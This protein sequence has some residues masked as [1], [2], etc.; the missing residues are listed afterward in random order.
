VAIVSNSGANRQQQRRDVDAR[1]QLG[2]GLGRRGGELAAQV[3]DEQR[4]ADG[5]LV[6]ARALAPQA[7]RAT[8]LAVVGGEQDHRVRGDLGVAVEGAQHVADVL[9]DLALELRVEVE[10]FDPFR[11]RFRTLERDLSERGGG[12]LLE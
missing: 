11:F 3:L 10:K 7:V 2:A 9:V 12:R 1:A 6:G 4:H 8:V 5:L